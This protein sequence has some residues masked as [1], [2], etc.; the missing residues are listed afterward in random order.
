MS[1]QSPLLI[2]GAGPV[3]LTM[4]CELVRHGVRCRVIDKAAERST[5]SKALGIFP[6]TLEVFESMGV[7][8]RILV[9]GLRVRGLCI[10]NQKEQ[11][12]EIEMT[13]VASPYPF[14]FS[15]PQS[16]TERIL[17]EHLESSGVSVERR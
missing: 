12:A 8:D 1:N 11:I 4:A 3:G 7:I 14:V 17:I 13:S 10:H 2:V 5:T 16:E 15:L 6:R 9:A